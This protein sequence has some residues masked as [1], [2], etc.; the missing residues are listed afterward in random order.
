MPRSFRSRVLTPKSRGS[1]RTHIV[2][3]QLSRGQRKCRELQIRSFS[4]DTIS[5]KAQ[6]Y[7]QA[8]RVPVARNLARKLILHRCM[9]EQRAEALAIGMMCDTRPAALPPCQSDLAIVV[10]AGN[11]D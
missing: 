10:G 8:F 2:I 1:F 11:I 9:R 4:N 5:G 7:R 6:S 3:D